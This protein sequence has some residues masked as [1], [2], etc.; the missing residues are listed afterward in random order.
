MIRYFLYV[1]KSTESEE[2]QVLSLEAQL[3]ECKKFAE[4]EKLKIVDIFTE[5]KTA[6]KIGRPVFNEMI[7]SLQP[8]S[9]YHVD[10][11]WGL[12]TPEDLKEYLL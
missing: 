1:R 12:G 2:R 10:A 5:S 9:I 7:Q 8:I 11:M 4:N 6:K 3:T